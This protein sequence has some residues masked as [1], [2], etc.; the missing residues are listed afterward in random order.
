MLATLGGSGTP[1]GGPLRNTKPRRRGSGHGG[2]A[3]SHGGLDQLSTKEVLSASAAYL[4]MG[5]SG[6][7]AGLQS[8]AS[9]KIPGAQAPA[10]LARAAPSPPP[11]DAHAR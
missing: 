6:A 3:A 10:A 7:S 11:A 2:A 5:P 8:A 9:N 1:S 4:H